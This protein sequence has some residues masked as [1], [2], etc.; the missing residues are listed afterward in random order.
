MVELLMSAAILSVG[1][2]GLAMLQVMVIRTNAGSRSSTTAIK[3]GQWVA[4]Q[5]QNEGRNRLLYA[6]NGQTPGAS[7]FFS[8]NTAIP[9]YFDF[10]GKK[11][12]VSTPNAS[13]FFTVTIT[14]SDL[15]TAVTSV[16]A[17]KQFR[18]DVVFVDSVDPANASKTINRTF[19]FTRQVAYANA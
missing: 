15:C 7:T 18:I 16:G 1:V 17:V 10:D 14:S 19:T 12:S 9:M 8:S 4:D 13:T 3:V 5:I 11:Q 2:L 6:R